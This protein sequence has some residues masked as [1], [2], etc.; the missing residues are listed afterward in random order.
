M[1][2]A[3]QVVDRL[4]QSFVI[5]MVVDR[6]HGDIGQDGVGFGLLG[7][8]LRLGFLGGLSGG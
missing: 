1:L 2:D 6:A 4:L 3:L 5:D 8:A 7:A